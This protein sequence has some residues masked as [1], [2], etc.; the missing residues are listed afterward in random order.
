MNQLARLALVVSLAWS[1][2]IAQPAAAQTPPDVVR[3]HDGTF[4]RGTIVER[5]PTQLVVMLPTGETR[6]Y[7]AD[8]VAF[9][10][11]DV[12][13]V[14]PP[15]PVPPPPA[16][17][18]APRERMARLHVRTDQDSLSLQQLQGTASVTVWTGNGAGR[19]HIDQ[20]GI[21]CNAPCDVEVPEGTYQLGIAHGTGSAMRAGAPIDLRG[22][23]TL[24]LSYN[25]RTMTRVG[26]WLTFGLGTA[27]GSAL[28]VA[29][30]FAGPRY[31]SSYGYCHNELSMP[32]LIAGGV[33]A[34]VSMI[35]GMIFAFMNDAPVID[36]LSDGVRF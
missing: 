1:A 19:A 21:V 4:L 10:G 23:V 6:T 30:I 14:A 12:P 8:E 32:M 28:M 9:A 20:F 35:V 2:L 25:D 24:D 5:S 26:G 33:V 34:G 13:A 16:V 22:D 17:V 3:L 36:V 29:S 7:A 18:T 15:V 31:C 27:G 11:P